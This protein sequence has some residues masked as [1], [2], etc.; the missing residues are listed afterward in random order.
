MS[1]EYPQ[2]IEVG[3]VKIT[4]IDA[5]DEARWRAAPVVVSQESPA[6]PVSTDVPAEIEVVGFAEA[7]PLDDVVI[8]M[9]NPDFQPPKKA[10]KS[11]KKK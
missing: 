3:G 4:A 2:A 11:A 10:S 6:E 5:A 7:D 8:E 9:D 1:D